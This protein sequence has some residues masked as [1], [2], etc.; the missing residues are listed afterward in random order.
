[1]GLEERVAHRINEVWKKL[2]EEIEFRNVRRG[3]E[4]HRRRSH[5]FLISA[6]KDYGG[7]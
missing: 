5:D 7:L 1:M 2:D 6:V 3:I 4:F